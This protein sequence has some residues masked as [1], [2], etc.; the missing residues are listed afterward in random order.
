MWKNKHH[1]PLPALR[2]LFDSYLERFAT[3]AG[4]SESELA[5]HLEI[6]LGNLS[7]SAAFKIVH[8]LLIEA[9]RA[10]RMKYRDKPLD[11]AGLDIETDSTT[12]EPKLLGIWYGKDRDYSSIVN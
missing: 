6:A 1:L 9:Y 11:L 4:Q 7:S 3:L 10:P 5:Q 8:P 2:L 12:G